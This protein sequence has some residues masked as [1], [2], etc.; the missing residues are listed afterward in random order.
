MR[1][2]NNYSY[3]DLL[4]EKKQKKHRSSCSQMFYKAGVVKNFAKFTGKHLCR[5][6][7]FN[8]HF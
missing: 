3:V 7:V 6:L 8:K 2:S 5:S 4:K 1:Q